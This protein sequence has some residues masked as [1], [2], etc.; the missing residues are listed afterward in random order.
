VLAGY[1]AMNPRITFTPDGRVQFNRGGIPAYPDLHFWD[2]TRRQLSN[3]A[4]EA[5]RAG[6]KEDARYYGGLAQQMNAE[7]D[8]LV[9]E[10]KNARSTAAGFFG[11]ENA[12]E[13]GRAFF[14]KGDDY[15]IE[16]TRDALGKMSPI[17]RKLFEDGYIS[18]M[19]NHLNDVR[20]THNVVGKI[21]ETP[22]KLKEMQLVLGPQRAADLMEKMRLE[23]VLDRARGALGNS[24]TIRQKLEAEA[25]NTGLYGSALG[26]GGLG[27][28]NNWDPGQLGFAAALAGMARG[29]Q[30]VTRNV[31]G[32]VADILAS[33]DPAAI[34]RERLTQQIISAHRS[35]VARSMLNRGILGTGEGVVTKQRESN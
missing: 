7:L 23:G 16:Q 33:R 8:K 11:Q 12:L 28:Y 20:H 5:G 10:Y 31:S 17:Q 21:G 35:A 26:V 1:G 30:H 34:G 22:N 18:G 13:A 3:A 25:L 9:P 29:R 14:G 6:R 27:A 24:T 19:I 4:D 15:G 2:L 32:H